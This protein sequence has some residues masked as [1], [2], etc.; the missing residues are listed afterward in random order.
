MQMLIAVNKPFKYYF[1]SFTAEQLLPGKDTLKSYRESNPCATCF[2]PELRQLG[3][4][5]NP[6][7]AALLKC[8]IEIPSQR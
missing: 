6:G 1:K 5:I 3:A 8:H 2:V 7:T 4:W